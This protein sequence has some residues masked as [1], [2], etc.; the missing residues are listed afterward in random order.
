MSHNIRKNLYKQ[1]LHLIAGTLLGDT[2][3][4]IDKRGSGRCYRL[5][6]RHTN[7]DYFDYKVKLLN[8]E[9]KINP[10]VTGY[11]S[12]GFE[13]RSTALTNSNFPVKKFYYTGHNNPYGRKFLKYKDLAKFIN[14]D[15]LALW[16][17][18][19][20]GLAYNNG[21][22]NTPRL[23][24]HTQ[25][26]SPKQIKEY[27]KLFTKKF[28]CKPNVNRDKKVKTFGYFLCFT[29]KDTLFLL[30]HLRNKHV[31]GVEYKFYFRTEGYI[32]NEI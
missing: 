29:T 18:D 21:N 20:G 14:L 28:N 3:F 6:F 4:S 31:K 22:K 17:A 30:N 13:F 16:I 24:L 1:Q 7:K 26:S 19:D 11:G 10:I 32:E 2:C 25:N 15:A 23:Y 27:V 5:V 12:K 9:G 8:L